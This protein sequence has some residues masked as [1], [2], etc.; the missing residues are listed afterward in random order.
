MCLLGVKKILCV[1]IAATAISGLAAPRKLA[2]ASPDKGA[3][4]TFTASGTFVAT[5]VSGDDRLK[6]AGQ[7]FTI[8]IV[9]NSSLTPIQHGQNWASFKPLQMTGVVYSGLIPGLPI[10]I[11]ST[12]ATLYQAIGYDIGDFFQAF[13]PVTEA[14]VS[15][16]VKAY[17][18]LP[19]GT[20][21]RA[22]L[23]P[24]SSVALNSTNV[25][26][27][28][29]NMRQL[30]GGRPTSTSTVLAVQSGTLVATLPAGGGAGKA[31]SA[32][33]P[34][35]VLL[36]GAPAVKPRELPAIWM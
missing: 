19:P 30:H 33:P 34:A 27:T 18:E 15:L 36:A 14:D 31:T 4:I 16:T 11:G 17:I 35:V 23:R 1:T 8:T 5:P 24:F 20:L 29:S 12:T 25:T 13:F 28:Y 7:Q 21:T 9:G 32:A 6:L 3:N 2:A 10:P 22:L 26:V